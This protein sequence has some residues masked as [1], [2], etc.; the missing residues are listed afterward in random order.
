MQDIQYEI[1]QSVQDARNNESIHSITINSITPNEAQL[2]VVTHEGTT[3]G[4]VMTLAGYQVRI[5]H[6][7]CA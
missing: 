2:Q 4:I 5:G 3:L 6:S 7:A 1:E